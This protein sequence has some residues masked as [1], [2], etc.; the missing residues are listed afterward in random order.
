VGGKG[1]GLSPWVY[2]CALVSF[3][4]PHLLTGNSICATPIS[5]GP[6]ELPAVLSHLALLALSLS[7]SQE[8]PY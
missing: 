5:I 6:S 7:L 8:Q 3:M 2:G 1:Q 4:C